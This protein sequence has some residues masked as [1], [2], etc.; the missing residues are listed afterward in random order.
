MRTF[1]EIEAD[2]LQ[3]T[4]IND[5]Q[6]LL[7]FADELHELGTQDA[8]A[9]ACRVRGLTDYLHGNYP[10]AL[11]HYHRALAPYEAMGNRSGVAVVTSNIGSAHNDTGNYPTALEYHHRALALFEELGDRSGV[12]RVTGNIGLV[13]FHTGNY[14]AALELFNRAL[15]IHEEMGDRRSVAIVTGNIGLVH[16]A[17]GNYPAAMEKFNRALAIYE[18][19]GNRHGVAIVTGN[20]GLAHVNTG[21]YPAALEHY[22]RALAILEELGDR[23]G[24]ARVTV[25][26]GSVYNETG[27]YPAALEQKHRALA[28]HEELGER[29]GVALVTGNIG[30]VHSDTGNYTAALEYYH[31]ALAIH[32]EMG[33]RSGVAIVTGNIGNV[34]SATG[35]YTAALEHYHH[36]LAIH[37]ELGY[38]RGVE[39]VTGNIL[40]TQVCM[41]ADAEAV[42]TL[43]AMD[44]MQIDTPGVRI[45]CDL[46]RAVLQQRKGLL[47]DAQSTLKRAQTEAQESGLRSLEADAHKELRDLA[48]KRNDFAAYIEHNNEFTRITEEINGKETAT[49]LAMQTKQREIEAREREHEKHRT[50]LYGTLPKV[51]ADRMIRGEKVSG[52]HYESASVIFL[53]IVGFT[54]ISDKIPPGHVVHLLSHIFST[55]DEVC[56]GHGVTKIKTIGDSYMAVAGVPEAQENHA[57]RAAQCALDMLSALDALEIAM[58]P[59]LGE[60]SWTKEVGEIQVRIGIHCGP[61]TAGVIGT[62]RLQY[63]VWGDTVNV[64][65]RME[66]TSEPGRIQVS[67]A[68]AE[69]ATPHASP[70]NAPHTFAFTFIERGEIDIKGKGAMNTFWLEGA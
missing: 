30:I 54:S 13:H 36:A 21:N 25:N 51:V 46:Q 27:N 17:T 14:P 57:Q 4:S 64:A 19:I 34:Q 67:E 48:Q 29:R 5:A 18:E 22:H 53:D 63:D 26:I 7:R 40:S 70:V 69:G 32:E 50:L 42:A 61:V 6:A 62:E 68:F 31:R 49:K 38:R 10:A 55:L 37:E 24:V 56:K 33:D 43:A 60:T 47:D 59:D 1:E 15:A 2:I 35:N 66:S 52:D 12:A 8:E 39:S 20:I 9:L 3:A 23:R 44:A 45:Q 41:Q 11:E 16:N 65:S 58:P 28:I